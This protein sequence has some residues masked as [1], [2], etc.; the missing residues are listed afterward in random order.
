MKAAVVLHGCGDQDGTDILEV[1]SLIIALSEVNANV[2]F[3][4]PDK[5]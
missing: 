2:K 1:T 4:A 5:E 3:F